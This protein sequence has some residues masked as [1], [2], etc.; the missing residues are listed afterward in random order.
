MHDVAVRIGG[1]KPVTPADPD[2]INHL[3]A[4][5]AGL[6]SKRGGQVV[7]LTC[8]P[9]PLVGRYITVHIRYYPSRDAL[10]LMPY[11]SYQ[12]HLCVRM[13]E[14]SGVVPVPGGCVTMLVAFIPP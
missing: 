6:L 1:T 12:L 4:F 7:A 3:C 2:S 5:H 8:S 10:A 9:G 11:S 13:A 14:G